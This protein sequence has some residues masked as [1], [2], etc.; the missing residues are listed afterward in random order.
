MEYDI[1]DIPQEQ[2]ATPLFGI[3]QKSSPSYLTKIK[4]MIQSISLSYLLVFLFQLGFIIY[5]LFRLVSKQVLSTWEIQ[6][7]LLFI[8]SCQALMA[9]LRFVVILFVK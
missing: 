7:S 4:Q 9:F 6:V 1:L 2:Y 8:M 3:R 5:Y